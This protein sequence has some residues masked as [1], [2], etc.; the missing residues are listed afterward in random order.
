MWST[1]RTSAQAA[2]LGAHG[3]HRRGA[4][5]PC[6]CRRLSNGLGVRPYYSRDRL[7]RIAAT[8]GVTSMSTTRNAAICFEPE[9]YLLDGPK[10]MG[11][12]A[13]G[14]GFLRA[15]VAG[16]RGAMLWG[17]TPSRASGETFSEVVRQIDPAAK[18]K[19]IPSDRL[20]LLAQVGALFF[21]GPDLGSLAKLRLRAGVAAYSLVGVTH[22]VASHRVMDGITGLL[23]APVMPWDA[24]IC[25][26]RA[27]LATV[28]DMLAAEADYLRW[29]FGTPRLL[30]PRLPVIPLGVHRRDFVFRPGE[31]QAARRQFG[32]AD[33]EV[34]AL[35][36]GRLSLHAKAHPHAMYV[37]LQRAAE[38][39]GKRVVL[40]QSG[41]FAAPALEGRLKQGAAA[42]CPSVRALFADGGVPE[43]YRRSWAA[44]DLFVSLS[45]NIQETFGLTP[46][47]AMAAGL[48]VLVTDW[49]GYRDTVR[50]GIDGFRVPTW[51][52]PAGSGTQFATAY[53]TGAD[54]YDYYCGR[55]SQMVSVDFR[56]LT[57]RLADL[58]ANAE[59]RRTL[60]ESGRARV[61]ELFDW[62]V[63]FAQYQRLWAELGEIR[64]RER[65]AG[66]NGAGAGHPACAPGRLDPFHAF[67]HHPSRSIGPATQVRRIAN[68]S[69]ATFAALAA[70]P[71]FSWGGRALPDAATVGRLLDHLGDGAPA[72]EDLAKAAGLPEVDVFRAVAVLA[73][74]GLV[75]LDEP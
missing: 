16:A 15:A 26:S 48:P 54:N 6:G 55:T 10:L 18:P 69:Q 7:P 2:S 70:D 40:L 25:T 22:T 30:Q 67:R 1:R 12:Q 56:V 35:F 65:A 42:Y 13:A 37:G 19:W 5:R 49:D 44:A 28:E 4:A 62:K 33:D 71:L 58:V 34:V 14:N 68:A 66:A 64:A 61:R 17:Y 43:V 41:R 75:R 51:M 29:R 24:L 47:E 20:D 57:E 73:K 8:K 23:A 39:T 45:D 50:D 38:A 21:S 63:V 27:A 53:E 36:A 31:R 3:P 9:D 60:G 52:P 11:R 72:C 74:T 46:L 32:I 59:L